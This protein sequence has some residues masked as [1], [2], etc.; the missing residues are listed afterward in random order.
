MRTKIILL[1]LSVVL[2]V[3]RLSAQAAEQSDDPRLLWG[4]RF[5]TKFD[6]HENGALQYLAPAVN[7]MTLFSTRLV[8]TVGIGWGGHHRLVAGG[9]FTFDISERKTVH[10]SEPLVFYN[11]HSG[12]FDLYAGKFERRNL[13]GDYSRAIF[14]GIATFYDNVVDGFAVQYHP[15]QGK[16][17][18][19]LDWD[20]IK[21]QTSRERFRILS[22]GEFNPVRTHSLRWL[23]MGYS[24]GACHLANSVGGDFGVV[25]HVAV[26]PWIGAAFE[27]LGLPLEVLSLRI[28]WLQT[29]DR[30]R[31]GE[32]L[33]L[34]PGGG[35][36]EIAIQKWRVG[37]RN[38][39]YLGRPLMP[40]RGA[41]GVSQFASLIYRG[42]PFYSAIGA[43][44]IYNYTHIYWLPR[45]GRG[46]DLSISAGL[47]T[48]GKKVGFQQTVGVGVTLDGSLFKK[49]KQ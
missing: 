11:Y 2:A 25:D 21:T 7:S 39:L 22:A 14:A 12:Q 38:R 10:P 8:P 28:G 9:S 4:V 18:F 27:K 49:R 19:V 5:D 31:A 43:T 35:T 20:G 6:N 17:E 30:D 24:F 40:L 16:L 36:V 48:D 47:H 26:S 1:F 44:R 13:I 42:D 34:S 3:G 41:E 46:V 32:N 45:I 37:I 23:T 29:F 15:E 33:W